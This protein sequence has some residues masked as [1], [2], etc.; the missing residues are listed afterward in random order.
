MT[1]LCCTN[2]ILPHKG[3]REEYCKT[4]ARLYDKEASVQTS[5]SQT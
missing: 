2:P 3:A 5:C 4:E 1:S